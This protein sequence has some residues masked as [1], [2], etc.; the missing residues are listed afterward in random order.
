MKIA[1]TGWTWLVKHQDNHKY[2]FEQFLK[3]V[4]DVGYD[5]VE[6]FAF[7]TKYF[8]NDAD[9]VN[10][11]LKKY[12]LEMVNMYEHYSDDPEADYASAVA[13]VDF[14]KKIGATYL[15]LQG[16]MAKQEELACETDEEKIKMYAELSNKIGALCKENGMVA[17]FHPHCK[18]P[19]FT[20]EQIDLFL[21]N[22]NPEY[23]GLC[24][25]TAHT[26]NAGMDVIEAFE[27]YA[28]H[29]VYVHLKD[30]YETVYKPLGM[31]LLDFKG[32]CKVL[33]SHGYDGVLCVELDN[34]HVCNYKSA[35]ISRNYIHDV[36]GY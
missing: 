34:P 15:N 17:C 3:E 27:N 13:Y 36:L 16:T 20:K 29:I 18:T 12:N 24:L 5:S 1:Y 25:D 6:N 30:V 11:L 9:E 22:I 2:E 21:A 23:V 7:I 33:E 28:D 26:A 4:S 32:V 8:D 14:M 35:M 10:A 31:G 19:I